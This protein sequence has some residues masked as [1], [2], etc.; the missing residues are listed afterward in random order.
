MELWCFKMVHDQLEVLPQVTILSVGLQCGV[1][2]S[3]LSILSP[4]LQFYIS[5]SNRCDVVLDDA[6]TDDTDVFVEDM[7]VDDD[8]GACLLLEVKDSYAA[9]ARSIEKLVSDGLTLGRVDAS[10]S[11]RDELYIDY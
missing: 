2:P 6:A 1:K 4:L 9:A 10:D 3:S 7:A 11:G 5:R 8:A